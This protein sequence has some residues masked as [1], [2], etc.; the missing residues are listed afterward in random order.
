MSRRL[1]RAIAPE[2]LNAFSTVFTVPTGHKYEIVALSWN[3]QTGVAKNCVAALHSA[4]LG[5]VFIDET[6]LSATDFCRHK[7]LANVVIY[8]GEDLWVAMLGASA[9]FC[10]VV[11]TY[12]DV[13]FT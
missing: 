4:P 8:A 9:G 6:A 3:R 5:A 12:V 11:V 13:D 1:E 7:E 10:P 2:S